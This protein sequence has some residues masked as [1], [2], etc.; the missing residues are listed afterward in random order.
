[1]PKIEEKLHIHLCPDLLFYNF[2]SALCY[3]KTELLSSRGRPS[4]GFSETVK[5]LNAKISEKLPVHHMSKHFLCSSILFL[6]SFFVFFNMGPYGGKNS[7]ASPLKVNV[8]FTP[9]KS[10]KVRR[11][12]TKVVQRIGK[13][14][15]LVFANSFFF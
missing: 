4:P 12:F 11:V 3:C 15:I 7:N 2:S 13:F 6:R 14:E 10:C 5:R 1:M 9:Q 8:R